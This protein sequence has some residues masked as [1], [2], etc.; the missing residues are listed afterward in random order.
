MAAFP[1][2]LFHSIL[3]TSLFVLDFIFS[4][5][6][7]LIGVGK[8]SLVN[9]I[10]KGGS[11]SR[12]SQTIGCT[13][14]V[15]VRLILPVCW[16]YS[17]IFAVVQIFTNCLLFSLSSILLMEILVAPQIA[18]KGILREISLLNFGIYQDTRD[19]KIAELYSTHKLTVSTKSFYFLDD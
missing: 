17:R 15:K 16:R 10:V 11:F 14:G 7:I 19:T 13:V 5:F 4:N 6:N 18:S 3:V 2:C 9:L 12:P 1:H 8:T